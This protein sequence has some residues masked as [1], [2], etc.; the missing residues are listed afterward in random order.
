MKV[1]V[2]KS[3][4]AIPIV[5]KNAYFWA[6]VIDSLDIVGAITDFILGLL[7][8][9]IAGVSSNVVIDGFQ[10]A[11]AL[12]IFENPEVAVLGGGTDLVLPPPIDVFPTFTGIVFAL[13]NL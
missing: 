3:F 1:E 2:R 9:G 8:G 4:H 6:L 5:G 11:L 7:S 10:T 12:V 13:N